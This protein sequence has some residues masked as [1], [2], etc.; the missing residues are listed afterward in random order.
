[1]R[2]VR[3]YADWR[4]EI[5]GDSSEG[6]ARRKDKDKTKRKSK[7]RRDESLDGSETETVV[8]ARVRAVDAE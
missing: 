2:D 5:F 1:M 4:T 6:K 8:D 7:K 3:I